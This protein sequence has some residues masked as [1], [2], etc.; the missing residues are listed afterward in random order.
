MDAVTRT[1]LDVGPT[2]DSSHWRNYVTRRTLLIAVLSGYW[3][4]IFI[5]T[6]VPSIPQSLA[7]QGD[8]SLHFVAYCGLAVVLLVWC[9][10]LRPLSVGTVAVLWLVIAGYGVFDEVTQLLVGR[11]CEL[12]D[13]IADIIGAASGLL[14]TWPIASRIF[15]ERWSRSTDTV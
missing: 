12:G 5:G 8:K 1:D 14:I 11:D 15:R 3:I 9:A 10:R 6:H 13:W 7:D 2:R 4:T